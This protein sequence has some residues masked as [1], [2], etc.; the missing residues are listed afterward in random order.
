[1]QLS[2]LG[3]RFVPHLRY[4]RYRIFNISAPRVLMRAHRMNKTLIFK[5]GSQHIIS[6]LLYCQGKFVPFRTEFYTN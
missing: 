1:M 5:P 4:C 6:Y 3:S 2:R